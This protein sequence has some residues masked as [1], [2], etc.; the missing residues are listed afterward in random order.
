MTITITQKDYWD[1]FTEVEQQSPQ[2]DSTDVSYSY[3]SQLGTGYYRFIELRSGLELS[4]EQYQLH[5][6]TI[7][8][9]GD[10][11]HSLEMSFL[12]SGQNYEGDD[13]IGAGQTIFC[14]SGLATAEEWQQFD[15]QPITSI[16]IH[17]EPQ[18][19][20]DFW[21]EDNSELNIHWQKLFRTSEQPYFVYTGAITPQMQIALQQ[22]LSCPYI[23]AISEAGTQ[24][25]IARMYLESK[26]WELMALQLAQI[27][28]D[29]AKSSNY[30]LKKEERDRLYL[31][32]TILCDRLDNPPSLRDLAQE[33]GINECT[34]KRGFRQLFDTTVFGYLYQQRMEYARQLLQQRELNVSQV[35]KKVGYASQ[36]RFATAFRKKFGVNPKAFMGRF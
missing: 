20:I 34:L 1:F 33:I 3:P 14:G 17:I 23:G 35:A 8:L 5:D 26:V 15:E 18:I 36:S 10:R 7:V 29:R 12:L 4:I 19:V 30:T 2:V 28:E 16:S 32:Q 21:G 27:T 31:A 13:F 9:Q 25:V 22:I 11:L 24:G 6:R